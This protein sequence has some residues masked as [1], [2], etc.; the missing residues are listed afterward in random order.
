MQKV[1]IIGA[2]RSGTNILRD[3]LCSLKGVG[4]WPC[5]EINYIWRYGN[6]SH[7]SDELP[8]ELAS[9]K[10]IKY[11][12]KQFNIIE[13]KNKLH[14]IVEK[15]C[16][17]SLRV[18]FV[19]RIFPDARFLFIYRNGVDASVSAKKRWRAR[20][21]L[22]YLMKKTRYVPLID[23]PHYTINY[24]KNRLHIVFSS[25]KQLSTW[26]PRIKNL[27]ELK[28]KFELIEVC[29]I[30]WNTC[31][32]RALQDLRNVPKKQLYQI[33]YESFVKNPEVS[34]NKISNYFQLESQKNA[35]KAAVSK[36]STANVGKGKS[37]L[38]SSEKSI[39]M[40]HIETGLK[41]LGYE[42]Q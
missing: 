14:T 26:G 30:Q 41:A 4:T 27:S 32:I 36:V 13:D 23:L 1:I 17:N 33:S 24:F 42:E 8:P 38:K 39:L 31:V 2:P 10:S 3:V 6:A 37:E 19:R 20:L 11:I 34:L 29:G 18:E 15:T 28:N 5:D 21:D 40:P 35:I 12:E 25:K 7:S 16:A 22:P 9:K